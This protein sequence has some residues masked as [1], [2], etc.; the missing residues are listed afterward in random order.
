MHMNQ[1]SF[2][3]N[4]GCLVFWSISEDERWMS[5]SWMEPIR[6]DVSSVLDVHK[7]LFETRSSE[8]GPTLAEQL[9]YL[10]STGDSEDD[11]VLF[12]HLSRQDFY[13]W[14]Q[15][16]PADDVCGEPPPPPQPYPARRTLSLTLW[17][18]V[19]SARRV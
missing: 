12:D 14:A 13:V 8:D 9:Q 2:A 1:I 10:E 19:V 5:S 18:I 17:T 15:G 4:E 6:T 16:C 11:V 3:A 7:F